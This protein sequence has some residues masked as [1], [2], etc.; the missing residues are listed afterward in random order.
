MRILV[1]SAGYPP[2]YL[3][4]GPIRS[5]D[6]MLSSAGSSHEIFVLTNNYETGTSGRLISDNGRWVSQGNSKVLYLDRGFRSLFRGIQRSLRLYPDVIYANSLFSPRTSIIF[7]I[8]CRLPGKPTLALA[9][10]GELDPGALAIRSKK[11]RAYLKWTEK[12]KLLDNIIWHASS[13]IEAKNI[14]DAIP[15]AERI[16]VRENDTQLPSVAYRPRTEK[17]EDRWGRVDEAR[18][19]VLKAVFFSRLSQKKGLDVALKALHSVR[20][21]V[22]LDV[23]GPEE[24]LAYVARCRKLSNLLPEHIN[25]RF[26]GPIKP[27]RTRSVLAEYDLKLFPTAAEN[28]AHVIAEC[29][30]VACPVMCTDATPWS[31]H[32][33]AGGGVV[34]PTQ[35]PVDW[36]DAIESY[37]RGGRCF[38]RS[39]RQSAADAYDN[40]RA[41][42][43]KQHFFE[44]L[45]ESIC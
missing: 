22:D 6:A 41:G 2:A 39:A 13:E 26:M 11:K 31:P 14:R 44:L 23:F 17:G 20:C 33:Y 24:D 28:F 40:W 21:R 10:R 36:A 43:P 12:A 25:V 35:N 30:S 1:T 45:E 27:S 9:P 18:R 34:V 15:N 37:A 3:G 19:S 8:L 42:G 32:L 16:I 4:G 5:I 29:L 38:W 7:Q